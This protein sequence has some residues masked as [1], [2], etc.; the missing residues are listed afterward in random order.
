MAEL[1]DDDDDVDSRCRRHNND[2][3]WY[4]KFIRSTAMRIQRYM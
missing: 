1:N 4:G 2:F 3:R